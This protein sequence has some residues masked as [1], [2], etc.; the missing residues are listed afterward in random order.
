MCFMLAFSLAQYSEQTCSISK[1][2]VIKENT[3]LTDQQ[4][5]CAVSFFFTTGVYLLLIYDHIFDYV[6]AL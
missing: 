6:R 5:N 4:K 1:L 3:R 2:R